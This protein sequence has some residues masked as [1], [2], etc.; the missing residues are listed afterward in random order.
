MPETEQIRVNAC[1]E[2]HLDKMAAEIEPKLSA[3]VMAIVGP[4]YAGMDDAVR[5]GIESRQ[6]RDTTAQSSSSTRSLSE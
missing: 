4:I 3:H 2:T 5:Q 6:Q 1:V